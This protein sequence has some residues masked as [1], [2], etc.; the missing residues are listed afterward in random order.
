MAKTAAVSVA[1]PEGFV[2][3]GS[4][5]AVGWFDQ[6]TI[7]NVVAG[8][9]IGMFSR[10]DAL[11]TEGTS[12]FFQVEITQECQVRVERGEEAH[13]ETAPKGSII[14]VN[15]GPKTKP[16]Q[17]LCEQIDRGASYEVYGVI[18][19]SKIKISAGRTMHNFEVMHKMTRPPMASEAVDFDGSAEQEQ[20]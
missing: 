19:G 11:R 6:G 12:N 8:N 10:K 4:A 7:G 14:N 5:N 15:Y 17:K 3:S 16:W 13:M 18:A 20:G 1:I 2:R 9:L